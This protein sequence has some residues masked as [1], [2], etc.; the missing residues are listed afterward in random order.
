V[1][2][3]TED[4]VSLSTHEGLARYSEHPHMLCC[5][6][7]NDTW[8][9]SLDQGSAN[10]DLQDKSS[11]LLVFTNSFIGRQ[12]FTLLAFCLWMFHAM[13]AELSS[14]NRD[15]MACKAGTVHHL[16]AYRKSLQTLTLESHGWSQ[17][18]GGRNTGAGGGRPSGT[19]CHHMTSI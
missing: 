18:A 7:S 14:Y 15:G 5:L 19:C 10:Y 1:G 4:A 8:P 16:T 17:L 6:P 3:N 12:S 2:K 13:I 9:Y 11:P